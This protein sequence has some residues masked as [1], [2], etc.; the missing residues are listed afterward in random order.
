MID[1][2]FMHNGYHMDE[3][4]MFAIGSMPEKA[5]KA[6]DAAITIH[7]TV[8]EN[9]KPGIPVNAL[10]DISAKTAKSLGYADQYLGPNGYKVNFIG[11]GLGVEMIEPPFIAQNRR[12]LLEPGMVF[13]LEPK[14]VFENEFSAG[15]ESVF[16]VT[17]TG[18][19]LVS[20]VAVGM[21]VCQT[22]RQVIRQQ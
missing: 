9:V 8:L 4:R 2:G 11:H 12:D 22:R 3:T 17:E 16:R 6:G 1:F 19:E 18:C 15:I 7:N 20:K 10:F 21:F 14:M 13:A 5:R